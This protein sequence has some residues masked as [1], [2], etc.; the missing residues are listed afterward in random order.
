MSAR[1][2]RR[3]G[4][5]WRASTHA[6]GKP[7]TK[8][9]TAL[10]SDVPSDN[11][12]ADSA[13]EDDNCSVMLLHGVRAISPTRGTTTKAVPSTPRTAT[14]TERGRKLRRK[15]PILRQHL[16]PGPGCHEVNEGSSEYVV[17]RSPKNRNA[18]DGRHVL[19]ARNQH[20]LHRLPCSQYI[21]CVDDRYIG[22]TVC[23]ARQR[24]L[25]VHTSGYR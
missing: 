15:E 21:G 10:A 18:I 16:L 8:V 1:T 22:V 7:S 9:I 6:S 14:A 13:V 20:S 5:R 25:C 17:L 3:P 23:D 12:S 11:R 19:R 4:N 24:G 2:S